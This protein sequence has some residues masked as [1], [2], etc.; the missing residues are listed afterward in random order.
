MHP[1]ELK[2]GFSDQ[3]DLGHQQEV[4]EP[5]GEEDFQLHEIPEAD[6]VRIDVGEQG[7]KDPCEVEQALVRAHADARPRGLEIRDH[8]PAD[9]AEGDPESDPEEAALEIVRPL[10]P[11]RR[12]AD[13][14][15]GF[16]NR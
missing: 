1:A 15:D 2:A 4:E 9:D 3:G 11:S 8:V 13:V 12:V 16:Q 5:D 14:V 10:V 6:R 7:R